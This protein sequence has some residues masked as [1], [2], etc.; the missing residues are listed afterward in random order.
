MCGLCSIQ[1]I[2]WAK[3]IDVLHLLLNGWGCSVLFKK[4]NTILQIKYVQM[5]HLYQFTKL[6]KYFVFKSADVFILDYINQ[7]DALQMITVFPR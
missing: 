5:L 6:N 7:T 3:D 1:D 4:Q 2:Y